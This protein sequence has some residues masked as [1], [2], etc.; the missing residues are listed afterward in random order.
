MSN[1]IETLRH[2]GRV[3]FAQDHPCNKVDGLLDLIKLFPENARVA[4]IGCFAG[5]STE[6]FALTCSQVIA[7]DPWA[8]N[9]E[10]AEVKTEDLETAENM[11][12]ERMASYKNVQIFKM[13][14]REAAREMKDQSFDVI[15]IDAGHSFDEANADIDVWKHKVK[16]GGI[17]SGHDYHQPGVYEAVRK[18]LGL[19]YML[20][21]DMS[22]CK[23]R[24]I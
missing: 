17:I 1:R 12:R 22:W 18:N 11:F 13:K 6:V 7:I 19:P 2:E 20:F 23:I 16:I 4:E 14:S 24:A 8:S 5:V 10:Y 15:Y 3:W 21:S 9:G